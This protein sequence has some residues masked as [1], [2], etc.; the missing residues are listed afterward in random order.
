MTVP[1]N[2]PIDVY[3]GSRLRL[4][5]ISL[6]LS[7]ADVAAGAGLSK[8]RLGRFER[9][10]ERIPADSLY[11]LA[12]NLNVPASFFFDGLAGFLG[13]EQPKPPEAA[14]TLTLVH[15]SASPQ[16]SLELIRAFARIGHPELRR[17][18]VELIKA[19]GP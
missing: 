4:R 12:E 3:I 11:R 2:D 13:L 15:A 7:Q 19:A 9:G 14:G 1:I 5:R 6:A 10:A 18:V 8:A 16:E 17:R